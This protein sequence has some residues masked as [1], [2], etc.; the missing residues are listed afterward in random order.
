MI[1]V[2]AIGEVCPVPIIMTKNA[3]KEIEIG[4]VETSVD[5]KISIENLE[6]LAKEL[7]YKYALS[8]END[9]YKIIITKTKENEKTIKND[10]DNTVVVIDSLTMGNGEKELGE[11]LM[12]G[13]IYTL[14]ELEVLPKTILLYN[15]GVKLICEGSNS[16]DD[17]AKLQDKGVEIMACGVCI[18][19]Y[20]LVDKIKV[21]SITN[22]Y[23]IV[24]KQTK[25][26]RVIKP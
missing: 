5:N 21:G 2:N 17:L 25:G 7:G 14:T 8:Q 19:Y 26:T 6:K 18:N 15:E 1:K 22:M 4:E 16:L 23:N 12:K 11:V 24:S 13:F 10:E 9:I 20:N 3:L